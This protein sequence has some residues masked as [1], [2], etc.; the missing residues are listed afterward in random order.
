MLHREL[1]AASQK[2]TASTKVKKDSVT[3]TIRIEERNLAN[4]FAHTSGLHTVAVE[5]SSDITKQLFTSTNQ[6]RMTDTMMVKNNAAAAITAAA[7][8]Y[9]IKVLHEHKNSANPEDWND[10]NRNQG[11]AAG[12][13]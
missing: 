10:D 7:E 11:G 8:N 1:K 2:Y 13:G 6:L 3:E 5:D 9:A 12:T 4:F